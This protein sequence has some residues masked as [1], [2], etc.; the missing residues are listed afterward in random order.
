[1]ASQPQQYIIGVDVGG[2]NTDAVLLNPARSGSE[3][4]ISS[5]KATTGAN[6]TTGIEEAIRVLL[7]DANIQPS[8]VASLMIGTTHLINAVVERDAS[9]L[10]KVAVLRLTSQGYLQYTPPF[11]DFPTDLKTSMFIEWAPE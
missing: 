4:V 11:I 9:R 5:Y 10:S 6:V 8:Q 7:K 2:T 3:A 1:M